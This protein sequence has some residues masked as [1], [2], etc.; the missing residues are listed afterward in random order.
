MPFWIKL[1]VEVILLVLQSI[2]QQGLQKTHQAL[3]AECEKCSAAKK[4]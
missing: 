1:L 4:D 2:R 3:K